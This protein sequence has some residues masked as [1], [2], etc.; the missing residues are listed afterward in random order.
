MKFVVSDLDGTLLNSK[1]QVSDYTIKVINDLYNKGIPFAIATGRAYC[2]TKDIKDSIGIPMFMICNNGANIYDKDE[3]LIYN[4]M[5]DENTVKEV[6]KIL[7]E[8]KVDY[9]VFNDTHYY[10]PSYGVLDA[11]R[12][13]YVGEMLDDYN[14]Y[15]EGDKIIMVE[16]DR[17]LYQKVKDIVVEKFS[18]VLE[19][20]SS[21]Q[22]CLDF[23]AKNCSKMAAL[24]YILEH[25]D[26]NPEEVVA[27]GDSENDYRMLSFVGHPVAMKDTYM[28]TKIENISDY[29]ND[30]DG[31]AR[32][33]EKIFR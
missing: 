9:R 2:S 11:K 14:L 4:S 21:S 13:E 17:E 26:I 20:A 28:S 3:N 27:F 8:F 33:L 12:C 22:T 31:V 23:N 5:I 16:E 32:Y 24:K 1:S 30:E 18:S 15:G 29:K 7:Q 25:Y 6:V 19:I 10:Y